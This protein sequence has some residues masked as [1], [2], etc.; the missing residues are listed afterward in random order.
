MRDNGGQT[1][2]IPAIHRRELQVRLPRQG[3]GEYLRPEGKEYQGQRPVV[4][5]EAFQRATE[6]Q[7]EGRL[8]KGIIKLEDHWAAAFYGRVTVKLHAGV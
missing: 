8:A 5:I 6:R 7:R 1:L 2:A 3:L 4:G